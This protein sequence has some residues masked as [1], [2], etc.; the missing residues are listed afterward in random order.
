MTEASGRSIRRSWRANNIPASDSQ[1]AR[2]GNPVLT[3]RTAR[4]TDGS[5]GDDA[6]LSEWAETKRKTEI[7]VQEVSFGTGSCKSVTSETSDR[8]DKSWCLCCACFH[9]SAS[10]SRRK[11]S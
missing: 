1:P 7:A 9:A 4:G 8:R 3:C 5:E 11:R 10:E 6:A 2:E